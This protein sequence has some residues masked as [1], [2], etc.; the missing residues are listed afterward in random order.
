M[1][2]EEQGPWR[3]SWAHG[4]LELEP[5]ASVRGVWASREVKGEHREVGE[6]A[7]VETGAEKIAFGVGT[8]SV[9][10]AICEKNAT[11]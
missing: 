9:I 11:V 4:R 7:A 3:G 6:P 2:E 10:M 1:D 8:D 5:E